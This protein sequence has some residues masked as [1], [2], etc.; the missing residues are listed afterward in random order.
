MMEDAMPSESQRSF[1]DLYRELEATVRRLEAG[2]L[3]L[4]ESLELFERA[5]LLTEQCNIVLDSAELRVRQLTARPDGRAESE[6]FESWG[7]A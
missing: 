1:E 6:P 2:E 3:T 4:D 7:N 5:T